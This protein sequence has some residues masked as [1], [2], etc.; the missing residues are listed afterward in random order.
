[1]TGLR[2]RKVNRI[3]HLQ[4]Q[5]GELQQRGAINGSSL[6]WKSVPAYKLTDRGIRNTV[7]YH[8]MGWDKR[9]IDLDELHAPVNHVVTGIRFR[10]LGSHLNMEIRI[11]EANFTTGKLIEAK[12]TSY[13]HSNDNTAARSGSEKRTEVKLHA[14]DVSTRTTSKSVPT[15]KSNQYIEFTNTDIDADVAQTTVP[16]LDA[17]DVTSLPAIALAGVG[18]YHKSQKG[19][20]GFVAPKLFT[21][22]FEPHIERPDP[23]KKK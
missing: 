10:V 14:P 21:Y 9:A 22:D 6:D 7:D 5:Q 16:Y 3:I 12:T 18:L 23:T 1:M 4:I 19:F 13:W 2:F 20:G 8:T 15:S 11:T 17:Q